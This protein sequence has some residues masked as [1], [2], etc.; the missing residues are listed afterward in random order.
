MDLLMVI[1]A[2][3]FFIFAAALVAWLDKI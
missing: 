2:V 3:G 1:I